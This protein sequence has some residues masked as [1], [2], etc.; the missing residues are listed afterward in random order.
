MVL[1][2][3]ECVVDVII[4]VIL[5]GVNLVCY[6]F[7]L[8]VWLWMYLIVVRR[9]LCVDIVVLNVIVI[10]CGFCFWCFYVV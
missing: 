3:L 6:V 10:Y 7:G 1:S 9:F 5:V 8:L 4:V 2:C